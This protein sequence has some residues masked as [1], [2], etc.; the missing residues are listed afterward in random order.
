[1][2]ELID[3]LY[4][5]DIHL[6]RVRG[7]SDYSPK[8]IIMRRVIYENGLDGWERVTSLPIDEN[9]RLRRIQGA[10]WGLYGKEKE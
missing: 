2:I 5:R 1:M 6:I 9:T 3:E 8:L 10:M 7:D 4:Y